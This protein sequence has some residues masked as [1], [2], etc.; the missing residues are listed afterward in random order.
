MDNGDAEGLIKYAGTL[1]STIFF[2]ELHLH[3]VNGLILL[4]NHRALWLWTSM[5]WFITIEGLNVTPKRN[6]VYETISNI[7]LVFQYD[8]LKFRMYK[9]G[10]VEDGFEN[11]RI[12]FRELLCSGFVSLVEK[13]QC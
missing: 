4:V 1:S 13:S 7:F 5:I 3:S 11:T 12:I 10:P 6:L 2:M 8:V 9:S